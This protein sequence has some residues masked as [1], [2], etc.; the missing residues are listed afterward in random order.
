MN[1]LTQIQKI[2]GRPSEV[3]TVATSYSSSQTIALY[4]RGRFIHYYDAKAYARGAI[5]GHFF[6]TMKCHE[7]SYKVYIENGIMKK[8]FLTSKDL[9]ELG[10]TIDDRI[11]KRNLRDVEENT[12]NI[13]RHIRVLEMATNCRNTDYDAFNVLT[14]NELIRLHYPKHYYGNM[15][16]CNPYKRM[17]NWFYNNITC[18][19]NIKTIFL[20]CRVIHGEKQLET[21]N[22]K[23]YKALEHINLNLKTMRVYNSILDSFFPKDRSLTTFYFEKER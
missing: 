22:N 3:I 1:D 23:D 11:L 6:D 7:V 19:L 2:Y 10:I 14:C 5:H 4:I 13:W 16:I 8:E 15:K 12:L 18:K 9:E 21:L 20:I 17:W